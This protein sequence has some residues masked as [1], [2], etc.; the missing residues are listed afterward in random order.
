MPRICRTI[1]EVRAQTCADYYE[2]ISRLDSGIGLLLDG[3]AE[4]PDARPIRS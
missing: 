3:L 2:S 4:N 1:P